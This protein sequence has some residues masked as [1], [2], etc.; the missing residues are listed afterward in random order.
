VYRENETSLVSAVLAAKL[1]GDA[2]AAVEAAVQVWLAPCDDEPDTAAIDVWKALA[3]LDAI[4]AATDAA[5]RVILDRRKLRRHAFIDLIEAIAEPERLVEVATVAVAAGWP[6]MPYLAAPFA[7]LLELNAPQPIEAFIHEHRARLSNDPDSWLLV[8]FILVSSQVGKRK[9]VDAWFASWWERT[10]V[11][12]WI[13]IAYLATLWQLGGMQ[14]RYLREVAQRALAHSVPDVMSAVL[15]TVLLLDELGN[16]PFDATM[17]ARLEENQ[18]HLDA[19][20]SA[21]KLELPL[22]RYAN[23]VRHRRPMQEEDFKFTRSVD[24]SDVVFGAIA[25]AAAV[26]QHKKAGAVSRPP[27]WRIVELVQEMFVKPQRCARV[28]PMFI[29]MF[30]LER[31]DPR[32]FELGVAMTKQRPSELPM[33]QAPWKRMLK[34]RLTWK[35]RFKLS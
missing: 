15:S 9:D 8:A 14:P 11:P 27:D 28:F 22:V 19:L 2:K 13:V 4:R 32:A 6:A 10:G 21:P 34:Q 23:A 25:V 3:E 29:E 18:V 20:V 12:A 5:V 31:G 30:P 24:G 16:V 33:L 26:N 1:A 17:R 35:Q 7:R